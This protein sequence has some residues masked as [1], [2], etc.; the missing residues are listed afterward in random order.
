MTFLISV[1]LI[2]TIFIIIIL[3]IFVLMFLGSGNG[4]SVLDV[5]NTY[6]KVSG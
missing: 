6:S 3:N 2:I 5:V 4:Y 1:F